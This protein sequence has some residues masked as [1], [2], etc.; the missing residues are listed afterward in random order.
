M[1]IEALGRASSP[2][3]AGLAPTV[4]LKP[5]LRHQPRNDF[6]ILIVGILTLIVA[7]QDDVQSLGS[8]TKRA[9][10]SPLP[11]LPH[12]VQVGPTQFELFSRPWAHVQD[13]AK[14]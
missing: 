2:V 5:S 6:L 13:A 3:V 1:T 9:Q 10:L 12:P 8:R 4:G 7:R 11:H 14:L